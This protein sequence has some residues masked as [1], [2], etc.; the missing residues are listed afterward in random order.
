VSGAE[1]YFVALTVIGFVGLLATVCLDG[2]RR[3]TIHRR[4]F[5]FNQCLLLQQARLSPQPVSRALS[6]LQQAEA[7]PRHTG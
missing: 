5:F 3:E 4:T 2:A 7:T 6:I 1:R